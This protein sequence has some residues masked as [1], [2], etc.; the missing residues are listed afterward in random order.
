MKPENDNVFTDAAFA[1]RIVDYFSCQF[2]SKDIFFDPCAGEDGKCIHSSKPGKA[3]YNAMP[4]PRYYTEL[5]E[6]TDCVDFNKK[7]QWVFTN[8]PFS[9]K[10][11]RKVAKHCAKISDN[12]V[13]LCRL[14][15]SLGT[16]A[17][18]NDMRE[19]GHNL[20]EIIVVDYKDAGFAAR[21]FVLA[22]FHWQK[23]PGQLTKWTYW[24]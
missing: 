20:R 12:V 7:V 24:K 13:F 17:R 16:Y 22:V 2:M 11:Y 9:A 8:P 5:T 3:F 14:D 19:E 10:S 15:V 23:T 6:G 21:G 4:E 1:K 18:I